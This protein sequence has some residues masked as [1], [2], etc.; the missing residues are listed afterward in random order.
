MKKKVFSLHTTESDDQQQEINQL[1]SDLEQ[2][3]QLF[4][5]FTPDLNWFEQQIEVTKKQARKKMIRDLVVFWII[6]ICIISFSALFI[7]RT[8]VIYF[9]LQIVAMLAFLLYTVWNKRRKQV[10]H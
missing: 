1:R 3:D 10:D 9:I 7:N 4:P 6:A 8:P 5:V 2:M